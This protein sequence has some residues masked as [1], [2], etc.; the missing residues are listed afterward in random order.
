[1]ILNDYRCRR[2]SATFEEYTSSPAPATVPCACGGIAD[3]Q[4]PMPLVRVKLGQPVSRGA[5]QE[6]PPWALDT[7]SLASDG[8]GREAYKRNRREAR[9]RARHAEAIA[10]GMIDKRIQV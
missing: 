9:I 10:N 2:C 1:M 5:S 4:F 7:R 6:R 3:R 8:A